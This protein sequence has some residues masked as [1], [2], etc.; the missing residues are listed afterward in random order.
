MGSFLSNRSSNSKSQHS[1]KE[2]ERDYNER[3]K[4]T[5]KSKLDIEGAHWS[6]LQNWKK[7]AV[8]FEEI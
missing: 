6:M 3:I 2:L 1:K 5:A 7:E 8:D 4:L